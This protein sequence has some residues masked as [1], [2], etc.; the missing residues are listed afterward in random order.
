MMEGALSG[1]TGFT[2]KAGYCYVGSLERDGRRYVVA[3]LACGWPNNKSYK[4]SDTRK[5]MDYGLENYFNRDVFRLP[6][7]EPME[8]AEGIPES[9]RPYGI[10]YTEVAVDTS[11]EQELVW[12]LREDEAVEMEVEL[13]GDLIAPITAGD[14]VGTVS[15]RLEGQVIREYPVVTAEVVE[16][17]SFG[18]VLKYLGRLFCI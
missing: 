16:A 17:I 10:A 15:F 5:L 2:Q 12:L 18:W 11:G 7:L 1:K 8:V 6:T 9:G 4:W 14:R 3:L 13:A